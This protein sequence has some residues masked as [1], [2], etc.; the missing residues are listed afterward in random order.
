MNHK[1]ILIAAIFLFFIITN[2][3]SAGN[4]SSPRATG[5][6][7]AQTA[8]VLPQ[9]AFAWNP[10]ALGFAVK[11][12]NLQLSIL[13]TGARVAN[14]LF[15]V[16]EYNHYNGKRLTS[17]D[18]K[19]I[20]GMFGG[21]KYFQWNANADSR[22]VGAQYKNAAL[23]V[24]LQT[25]G[26]VNLPKKM[27]DILW[28]DSAYRFGSENVRA[29][30]TGDAS[31]LL[32]TDLS[33]GYSMKKLV[34]TYLRNYVQDISI[35]LTAGYLHGYYNHSV[36]SLRA[37][38]AD[39][40]N[41]VSD[42]RYHFLESQGGNGFALN[43]G[44]MAKINDKWSGGIFVRNLIGFMT[45][46]NKTRS[47]SGEYDLNAKGFF[48]IR[49]KLDSRDTSHAT[50]SYTTKLPTTLS[51][52]CGYQINEKI[53]LAGDIET[54]IADAPGR[55]TPRVAVGAEIRQWTNIYLRGGISA[56]GD[57]RGFS[58]SSGAKF[59]IRRWSVDIALAHLEGL[60]TGR[61]FA[62]ALGLNTAVDF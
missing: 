21:D 9:D 43:I 13:H 34:R 35:G 42:G 2:R 1:R 32:R 12:K 7:Q 20:L 51:V 54:F 55:V 11:Q 6:G 53:L 17:K 45:W 25:A 24:S 37:F 38:I 16:G 31:V 15:S 22:L 26:Y 33:Y 47:R 5:M 10:A 19:N 23:D 8:V 48:Q 62:F 50:G 58:L 30:G 27:L 40:S 3:L 49:D 52:G 41:L 14:N 29:S 36:K 28:S 57:N 56:G 46:T 60:V 61:R 18:Q 59:I 39:S 4:E 44:M